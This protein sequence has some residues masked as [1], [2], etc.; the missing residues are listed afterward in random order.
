MNLIIL[1]LSACLRISGWYKKPSLWYPVSVQ[2]IQTLETCIL[3]VSE[4]SWRVEIFKNYCELLLFWF[5]IL[6]H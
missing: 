1:L 2:Y 5:I 3:C 4:A 6:T